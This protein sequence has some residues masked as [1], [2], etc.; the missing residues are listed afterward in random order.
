[1]RVRAISL[2]ISLAL[3]ALWGGAAQGATDSRAS[4]RSCAT[5]TRLYAF[6]VET[7]WARKSYKRSENAVVDVT[8]TRPAPED[9]GENGIPVPAPVGIPQ[10]GA[11]VST[12]LFPKKR[13]FPPVFDRGITDQ[14]G[15][16][17]LAIPLKEISPGR[18]EASTYAELWTN[19]GGCPDIEEWG[20]HYDSPAFTHTG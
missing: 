13:V 10:E 4:A 18:V 6:T 8:V 11:T 17:R 7:K 15:R 5:P 14:G 19:E 12:T 1:M 9:P 3:G 2:A 16:V 20:Y